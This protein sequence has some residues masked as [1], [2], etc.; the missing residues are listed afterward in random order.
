MRSPAN[1]IRR[2]LVPL[3][4]LVLGAL[5]FTLA[6]QQ[7]ESVRKLPATHAARLRSIDVK[8]VAINLRFDWPHQQAYGTTSILLA[9]LQAARKIALDAGQLTIMQIQ[10]ANGVPL[11]FEYD[12]NNKDDGLV[13]VLDHEYRAGEDLTI[14]IDYHT[15]WVNRSDPNNIWGSFDKGLRFFEPTTTVPTK[16][17]QIWSMGEPESNRYWFPGYDEYSLAI[18]VDRRIE[19]VWLEAKPD[20]TFVFAAVQQPKVV[21]FDF[22]STWIKEATFVQSIDELLYPQ[23][24]DRDIL[25]KNWAMLELVKIAKNEQTPASDKARIYAGFRDAILSNADWRFRQNATTQL[26]D[27]M[28][29][30]TGT[31]PAALDP[32][33]VKMLLTVIRHDKPWNRTSTIRFLG[34]TRDPKYAEIYLQALNEPSDRV[35]NAAA[36]ALGMSKSPRGFDVALVAG[37]ADLGLSNRRSGI[38]RC[39]WQGR[40][41]ISDDRATLPEVHR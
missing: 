4:S 1:Q 41:G 27:L 29:T 10:L 31:T 11:P 19:Q 16:R 32:A 36:N 5:P 24:S 2:Q 18:E 7:T 15:N 35:I 40:H 21:N 6:A 14:Q 33:T 8:H 3:L 23:Q 30:A 22:E 28:V 38:H 17:R 37:H 39:I 34:M 12:G 25:G 20:N 26:R 13:V 9:P